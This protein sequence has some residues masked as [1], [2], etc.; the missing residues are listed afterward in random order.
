[1]NRLFPVLST[2]LVLAL[3]LAA[4]APA[5]TPLAPTNTAAPAVADIH[6]RSDRCSHANRRTCAGSR[7]DQPR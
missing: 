4:C 6:A 2:L 5:A 3:L 7:T 1:M